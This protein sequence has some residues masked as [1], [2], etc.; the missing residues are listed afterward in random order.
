[1]IDLDL[2]EDELAKEESG[3]VQTN[4]PAIVEVTRTALVRLAFTIRLCRRTKGNSSG[5][6]L[7]STAMRF[8]FSV[9]P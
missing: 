4:I 1:L 7:C 5:L 3:P 6:N 9:P 2:A 8:S